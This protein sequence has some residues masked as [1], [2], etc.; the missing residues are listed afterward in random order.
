MPNA[1][2]PNAELRLHEQLSR[3]LSATKA[4]HDEVTQVLIHLLACQ[5]ASYD[6]LMRDA[7]WDCAV[8]TLDDIIK[9]VAERMDKNYSKN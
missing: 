1:K 8:D 6:P 7:A 4:S 3:T 5:I 2:Q 9:E